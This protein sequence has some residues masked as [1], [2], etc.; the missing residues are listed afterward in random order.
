VGI[1]STV[2]GIPMTMLAG[3]AL[4]N[5]GLVYVVFIVFASLV[6]GVFA[7]LWFQLLSRMLG[8]SRLTM[9][10]AGA[11]SAAATAFTFVLVFSVP[12]SIV[13]R[14]E[15][16]GTLKLY[17]QFT[18]TTLLPILLVVGAFVGLIASVRRFAS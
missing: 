4:T 15:W 13:S 12:A 2:V 18:V 17:T 1:L 6:V 3:V 9:C 5:S 11:L 8:V 7:A 14:G 10:I 16:L